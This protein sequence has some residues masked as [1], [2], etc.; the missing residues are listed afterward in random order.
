MNY[1]NLSKEEL[2]ALL[3]INETIVNAVPIGFCIT[4]EKGIFETVNSHY[5]KIYGYSRDELIG[6]HFSIVTT[7]ENRETL[8]KLHDEFIE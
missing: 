7:E 6:K 3:N 5:S 2:I 8:T 4:N 1:D